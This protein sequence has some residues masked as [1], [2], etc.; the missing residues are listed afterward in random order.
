MFFSSTFFVQIG[1]KQIA[2]Q[3][4]SS[5]TILAKLLLAAENSVRGKRQQNFLAYLKGHLKLFSMLLYIFFV[6]CFVFEIFRPQ[7]VRLSA[8]LNLILP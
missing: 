5:E 4:S 6:S 2:L 1:G 3:T 8:I 7:T